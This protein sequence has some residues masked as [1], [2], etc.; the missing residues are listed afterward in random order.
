MPRVNAE[1]A[2]LFRHALL[3]DAAYQLQL[4]GDRGK[5]HGLVV[6][7]F[8]ALFA[9]DEP[10]LDASSEE[11]AR[12]ARLC[13]ELTTSARLASGMRAREYAYLL[14]AGK[15]AE[16][17]YHHESSA[18]LHEAAAQHPLADTVTRI[19][20]LMSAS[21]SCRAIGDMG[22]AMALAQKASDAAR[23][24]GDAGLLAHALGLCAEIERLRG[25]S[26]RALALA[27]E[28]ADVMEPSQ[29]GHAKAEA[30]A[31]L[32]MLL[33]LVGD[34]AA[35]E[36]HF[37]RALDLARDD[38]KL[39]AGVKQ[40]LG[41]LLRNNGRTREAQVYYEQ[42]LA[43]FRQQG[44]R[45]QIANLLLAISTLLRMVADYP[46]SESHCLQALDE[47]RSMGMRNN[48]AS[49][50]HELGAR[51]TDTGRHAE[52]EQ[53]LLQAVAM[54]RES[55]MVWAEAITLGDLGNLY[56]D[57]KRPELAESFY[58]QSL[59]MHRRN[60]NRRSEGIVLSNLATF[61]EDLGRLAEADKLYSQALKIHRQVKNRRFEGLV[62]G[63]MAILRLLTGNT[64]ESEALF[65]AAG[66]ILREIRA[67]G[68]LARLE[69][70]MGKARASRGCKP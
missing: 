57:T 41:D 12:H 11:L 58:L 40:H 64:V 54:Q 8:E 43:T 53:Y 39:A 44:E 61:Y 9:A 67:T 26:E 14:R 38:P 55:G 1:T 35:S 51:C 69:E 47:F 65:V 5:L 37:L 13:A 32:G 3:R 66:S 59:A 36:K 17:H 2:Y 28:A 45:K 48:E 60:G 25:D 42:A 18:S 15:F 50:L 31:R 62:M 63:N 49:A 34:V 29:V 19:R 4:P 22:R 30:I 70:A 6:A 56:A 20:C 52:G 68:E 10:L 23:A 16:R 21:A 24:C 33:D 27:R 7:A 46:A